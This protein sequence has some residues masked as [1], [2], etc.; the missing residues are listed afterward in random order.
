MENYG[1]LIVP[2]MLLRGFGPVL[3]I[4]IFSRLTGHSLWRKLNRRYAG[5][6]A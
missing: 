1:R 6:S 2:A 5:S 3:F 4:L